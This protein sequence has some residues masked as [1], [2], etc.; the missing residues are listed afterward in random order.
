LGLATKLHDLPE[1]AAK[2]API[3]T[4]ITRAKEPVLGAAMPAVGTHI[5]AMGAITPERREFDAALLAR[6]ACIAV[7]SVS[8][9]RSLSAEIIE[10]GDPNLMPLHALVAKGAR[11][12]A[13]ADLTLFKSL[14]VGIADLALAEEILRLARERKVGI[15][16]PD[17]APVPLSFSKREDRS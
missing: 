8:Q 1:A 14:G 16:L 3:I 2:S 4:L 10:A 17:P 11:R 5:N 9:A 7:D 12:P 13:N 15:E 6:C